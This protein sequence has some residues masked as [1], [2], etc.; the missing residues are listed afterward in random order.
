MLAV[1]QKKCYYYNIKHSQL[2]INFKEQMLFDAD[3][4][5]K[6]T[7]AQDLKGQ[8]CQQTTIKIV[9]VFFVFFLR[10]R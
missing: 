9:T 3:L 8:Q 7:V 6:I 10:I 1:R 4:T 2:K 5:L